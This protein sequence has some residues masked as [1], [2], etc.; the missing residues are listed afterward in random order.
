MKIS[1]WIICLTLLCIS[2]GSLGTK[3][4]TQNKVAQQQITIVEYKDN[5]CAAYTEDGHTFLYKKDSL[6]N[7]AV[8]YAKFEDATSEYGQYKMKEKL[9]R[10]EIDSTM[11]VLNNILN[12]NGGIFCKKKEDKL[13]KICYFDEGLNSVILE[14]IG[15]PLFFEQSVN[16]DD[17]NRVK[18][19]VQ[20]LYNAYELSKS[21]NNNINRLDNI[22]SALE[23]ISLILSFDVVNN[24]KTLSLNAQKHISKIYN[25]IGSL[26]QFHIYLGEKMN[27]GIELE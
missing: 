1:F 3:K 26:L 13:Y 2:C 17:K 16:I 5:Y 9:V 22:V 7:Y 4:N 24:D 19:I 15:V 14:Q 12:I 27:R 6:S 11:T 20:L 23:P 10:V 21:V 25:A 8:Y 18:R